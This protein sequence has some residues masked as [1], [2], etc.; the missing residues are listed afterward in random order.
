MRVNKYLEGRLTY[1]FNKNNSSMSL[2]RSMTSL[3]MCFG[4]VFLMKWGE[5]GEK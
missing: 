3:A 2:P 1:Q 4:V 5:T